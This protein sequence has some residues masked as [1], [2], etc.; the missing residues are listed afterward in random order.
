MSRTQR[1]PLHTLIFQTF[2]PAGAVLLGALVAI[3]M[4]PAAA[5]GQAYFSQLNLHTNERDDLDQFGLA[6]AAGGGRALIGA[7]FTDIAEEPVGS[8]YSF[9]KVGA[10][11]TLEHVFE[12]PTGAD[13]D[14]FGAAL[15]ADGVYAIIGAPREDAVAMDAGAAHVFKRNLVN[16]Q[17]FERIE[18]GD[19]EAGDFFGSA[20]AM[21]GD[22]MVVGAPFEDEAGLDAGAVYVFLRDGQT[23]IQRQKIINPAL[24]SPDGDQFGISVDIDGTSIIVGAPRANPNRRGAAYVFV[25]QGNSFVLEDTIIAADLREGDL[26]GTDVAVDGDD[27]VVGAE[28]GDDGADTNI[29]VAY[30]F[31]RQL[32]EWFA[33]EKLLR[34]GGVADDRFGKSV[35]IDGDLI[36]VGAYNE[37]DGAMYAYQRVGGSWDDPLRVGSE[38]IGAGQYFAIDVA[39]ED[40]SVIAGAPLNDDDGSNAGDAWEFEIRDCREGGVNLGG[41]GGLTDALFI[42]GLVGDSDRVLQVDENGPLIATMALPPGGGNGKYFVH[43]NVNAPTLSTVTP[44]P[45]KLG[46]FCFPVL[47][48]QGATPSAN[49]NGIGKEHK[50]GSSMY[51][52]GS[53]LADP[54]NAPSLFLDLPSGDLVHLPAGTFITLQGVIIDPGTISPRGVSV[55]NAIVVE[56]Q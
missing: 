12:S 27:A 44:L 52:D 41:G 24:T 28:Q 47:I 34:D 2:A 46:A 31:E 56:M 36:V 39:I 1:V 30:T 19:A 26:F 45:T 32:G 3:A 50:I 8:A 54:P 4:T 17:H 9:R 23:W 18:A 15:A 13:S 40:G 22:V 43:A 5:V 6:V 38:E 21:S 11:W 49:W 53:P 42:N 14:R 51:F 55:T 10:S 35:D 48:N 20:V 7:P 29:G 37:G 25:P 33:G 16:W